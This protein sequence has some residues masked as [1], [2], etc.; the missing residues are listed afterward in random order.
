MQYCFANKTVGFASMPS[1]LYNEDF[2]VLVYCFVCVRICN[3]LYISVK[4]VFVVSIVSECNSKLRR[5][6]GPSY[7]AKHFAF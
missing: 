4:G 1:D 6:A 7:A 3:W 2:F 5:R